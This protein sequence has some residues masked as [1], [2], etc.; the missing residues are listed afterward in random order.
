MTRKLSKYSAKRRTPDS[1]IFNGGAFLNVIQACRSFTAESIPG[2]N[3]DGTQSAAD[4]AMA[5]VRSAYGR[6]R[7]GETTFHD[8]EDFDLMA[9]ALGVALIRAEEIA[10]E[11]LDKNPMLEPITIASVALGRCSDRWRKTK[12][13]G[14]D[15]PALSE[16]LEGI[17]IYEEIVR[18]SSPMQMSNA[19][20][21][22][23]RRL[24]GRL[25]G[26]VA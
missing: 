25:Q 22:R 1:R 17:E 19:V 24:G 14:F 2:S 4:V 11:D 23:E 18:N 13:W 20:D 6:I 15:G 5:K 21:E 3:L 10:G 26:A 8:K 16:V 12:R 9:H 7:D